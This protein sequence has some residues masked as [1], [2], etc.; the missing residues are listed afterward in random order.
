MD[1]KN[2]QQAKE[3]W[4]LTTEETNL[5]SSKVRGQCLLFIGSSR[6]LCRIKAQNWEKKFLTGGGR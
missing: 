6:M 4:D 1:G 2:L 3:L 5:L